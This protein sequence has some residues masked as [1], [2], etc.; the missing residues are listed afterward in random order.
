M[1]AVFQVPWTRLS[2]WPDDLDHLAAL[3]YTIV[4]L[5]PGEE[6]TSLAA[7]DVAAHPHLA[8]I[9]GTE[10]AGVTSEAQARSDHRVSIP[11]TGGVDSLNVAA[12]A[13]V[14]FYATRF[15]GSEPAGERGDRMGP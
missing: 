4:A 2:A 7:F 6:S 9:L 3:G 13:A 10:G 11:M 12:A 15:P 5:T 14:A 1:G 8:L